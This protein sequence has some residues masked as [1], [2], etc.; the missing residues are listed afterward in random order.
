MEAIRASLK[1]CIGP[2]LFWGMFPRPS[3]GVNVG[4]TFIPL[5]GSHRYCFACSVFE[6]IVLSSC[7]LVGSTVVI[8]IENEWIG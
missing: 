2:P 8:H 5:C 1:P 3:N 6:V 7:V 4:Q